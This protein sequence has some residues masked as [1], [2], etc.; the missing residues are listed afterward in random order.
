MLGQQLQV[1]LNFWS[2]KQILRPTNSLNKVIS[3][4]VS[5]NI[6]LCFAVHHYLHD[7]NY[8][9]TT[10]IISLASVCSVAIVVVAV[11]A[12]YRQ[13]LGSHK[14]PMESLNLAE[15]PPT[16]NYEL[17]QLKLSHLVDRGRYGE[18]WKGTLNDQ[19]VAVKIFPAVYRQNYLNEKDIYCLPHIEHDSLLRFYG[20]EERLG[21]E[22]MT[23]YLLVLNYIPHGTL[24]NYLKDHVIDWS[25]LCRM[26]HSS[27]A[28]LSYLHTDI[29][30][31]GKS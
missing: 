27:A 25:T 11:Y 10:I 9:Q 31:G 4:H 14:P 16:P 28:G 30:V 5:D 8:R 17:E 26:C 7:Q 19:D 23:Q 1:R 22:G 20:A 12:V 13:C 29:S 15:T 2:L 24:L 18:V 21:S 3:L 6:I